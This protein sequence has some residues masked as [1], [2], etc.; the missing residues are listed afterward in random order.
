M[1]QERGGGQVDAS[2]IVVVSANQVSTTLGDE[3]VI[4]GADAG[5]YFGLNEVGAR[6]WELVQQPV[7]VSAIRDTLCREYDVAP[8]E[9]ERDLVELLN[10]LSRN[11]LVDVRR[12]PSAS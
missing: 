12:A 6:I 4:L 11:G 10:E 8:E 3:A 1:E 9:C 2:S 5:Q 7:S